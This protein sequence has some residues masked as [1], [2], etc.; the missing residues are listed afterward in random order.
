MNPIENDFFEEF[1]H[2]EEICQ[3]IYGR[4]PDNKLSVTLYLDDMKANEALGSVRVPGWEF[5]YKRLRE[6]R[7]KRNNLVHP[8]NQYH[9]QPCSEDDVDFL[10]SFQQDILDQTDPLALLGTAL[11]SNHRQAPSSTNASLDHDDF[12]HYHTQPSNQWVLLFLF[13]CFGIVLL[14]V[15]IA[16][17]WAIDFD[18]F[19]GL[20]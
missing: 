10:V 18:S 15:A 19:M 14:L 1:R 16:I 8:N 7:N 4:S 12:D 20:M 6:C 5:Q 2:L 17:A 11:R 9:T 3:Q 13:A